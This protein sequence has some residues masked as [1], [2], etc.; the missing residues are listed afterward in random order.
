MSFMSTIVLKTVWEIIK[1]LLLKIS[2]K[3]VLERF[4]SRAVIWGLECLKGLSTN[5]VV[6][7]TVDDVI[8]SLRGKRL[9]EIDQRE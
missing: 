8:A 2:W 7:E 6:Q 3:V 9:L 1:G 4:A 5:D